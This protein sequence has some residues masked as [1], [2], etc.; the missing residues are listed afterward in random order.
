MHGNWVVETAREADFCELTAFLDRAFGLPENFFRLGLGHIYQPAESPHNWLIRDNAKLVGVFGLFP[1][2]YRIGETVLNA[3]GV[4]GV[5]ADPECRGQGIMTTFLE[6]A[7]LELRKRGCDISWLGGNRERYGRFGWEQAGFRRWSKIDRHSPIS[8]SPDQARLV[9]PREHE[10]E[11]DR[12]FQSMP[13][14]TDR[15]L[16][17]LRRHFDRPRFKW[18]LA[19]GA[20][21]VQRANYAW[22]VPEICGSAQG[23]EQLL[24]ALRHSCDEPLNVQTPND[25]HPCSRTVQ[26]LASTAT[27]G[28]MGALKIV[29]LASTLQK[30]IP[31]MQKNLHPLRA[32]SAFNLVMLDPLPGDLGFVQ[33]INIVVNGGEVLIKSGTGRGPTLTLDRREMSALIFGRWGDALAIPSGFA[34]LRHLFP[35]PLYSYELDQ[36]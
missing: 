32:E 26:R 22:D 23:T 2:T 36:V 12:I 5:S 13:L 25:D 31:V 14:R 10:A 18:W 34:L 24:A 6:A 30:L 17:M 4:G 21:A 8:A 16:E 33:I 9:D 19:E 28:Q 15:S 20:Y 3:W 7:Q 11:I 35:A 29:N 27:N 1:M